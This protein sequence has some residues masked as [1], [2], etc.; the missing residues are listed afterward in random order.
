MEYQSIAQIYA[1]N[2]TIRE[3]LKTTLEVLTLEQVTS[4]PEGEKWTISQIVE[5]LAMVEEGMSKICAKLLSK[6]QRE[7]KKSRGIVE[8]SQNFIEKG[9]EVAT[10]KL[11]APDWVVP[12]AGQGIVQSMSRMD[13]NRKRLNDMRPLF[14]AYDGNTYKYPHPF[15]G[16]ISAVEWLTLVGGHEARHLRQIRNLLEKMGP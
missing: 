2:D 5:H 12:K 15:F 11:E 6:A 3:K 10:V 7:D 14:E 8:L 16:D 1:G 4:L 13:E 9:A